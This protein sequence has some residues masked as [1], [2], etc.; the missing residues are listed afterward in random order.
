MSDSNSLKHQFIQQQGWADGSVAFLA[1]DASNRTYDR[2]TKPD[3][4]RSVLMDAYGENEDV[5]PFIAIDRLLEKLG[6]S[7]PAILGEDLENRFLL[8]EDLGDKTFTTCLKE[9][10]DAYPLYESAI[11]ALIHIHQNFDVTLAPSLPTY[12][13]EEMLQKCSLLLEYYYPCIHGK[14]PSPAIR[15]SFLNAWRSSLKILETCPK[16]LILRDYHVDNLVWLEDRAGPQKCGLLDFQDAALGPIAY[17]LVSLLE[18]V[19]QDVDP[20]LTKSLLKKYLDHFPHLEEDSFMAQYYTAGAQRITRI[21]GVFC[22]ILLKTKR[23]H[24]IQFLPRAWKWLANDLKHDNLLDI[25][26]WFEEHF[27]ESERSLITC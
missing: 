21:M 19:R 23:D 5:R 8:L 3:G 11:E 2:L 1:G 17:D 13:L 9:G 27:P 24:Y 18:D 22:R 20:T 10:M 14:E 15:D 6:C 16:T 4:T 25:R 7:A 12:D 26:L